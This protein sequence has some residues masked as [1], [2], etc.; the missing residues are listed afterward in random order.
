MKT[1]LAVGYRAWANEIYKAV[2]DFDDVLLVLCNSSKKFRTLDVSRVSPDIVLF[3]GWSDYI[4]PELLRDYPCY[5][6]HP[7]PLPKYRGGS[8]IQ[9]QIINNEAES[10][11]TIFQMNE[12][13][14]AGPIVFQQKMSLDG[15]LN[16]IFDRII[17]LGIKGTRTLIEGNFTKR[18]QIHKDATYFA[19]RKPEH[20]EITFEELKHGTAVAIHNKVRMLQNPYPNAY[21]TFSDGTKL[22]LTGSYVG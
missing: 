2:S 1:I 10:A 14:D 5:M 18:E 19:R 13:I 9:N 8:P 20:S 21:F 17:E 7:S 22:Y 4:E 6:L 12:E 16:D 15:E 11:V 3:Y